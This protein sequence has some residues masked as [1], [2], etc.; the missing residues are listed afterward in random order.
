MTE[1][2]IQEYNVEGLTAATG[3]WFGWW[4]VGGGDPMDFEVR[5]YRSH[6]DAVEYGTPFAKEASGKRRASLARSQCP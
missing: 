4:R 3:A 5:F 1:Q 2:V 6:E